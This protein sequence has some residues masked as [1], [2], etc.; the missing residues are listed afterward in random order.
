[1]PT[2]AKCALCENKAQNLLGPLLGP[3]PGFGGS[4]TWCHRLCA[5]WSPEVYQSEDGLL[6]QV[7]AAVRRGR[8][9]KCSSCSRRGATV[10]CRVDS[11]PCCYHLP[12][13]VATHCLFNPQTWAVAC[14]RHRGRFKQEAL[15]LQQQQQQGG[16]GLLS[17]GERPL[18]LGAFSPMAQ[19][20]LPSPA[21]LPWGSSGLRPP[22][23][24]TLS[25]LGP[26]PSAQGS[27][28]GPSSVPFPAPTTAAAAKARAA[29][30][31]AI[32][33]LGRGGRGRGRGEGGGVGSEGGPG[34]RGLCRSGAH[35][36][37][38][39]GSRPGSPGCGPPSKRWKVDPEAVA[40]LHG[41]AQQ[42]LRQAGQE[43]RE[44]AVRAA[45]GPAGPGAGGA[46]E[47][48][49]EAEWAYAERRRLWKDRARLGPVILAGRGAS[50]HSHSHSHNSWVPSQ[51]HR[52]LPL[53]PSRTR[54]VVPC[55]LAVLADV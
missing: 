43:Q 40:A 51:A 22:L 23:P 9:M 10:G 53:G 14:P 30:A 15:A 24:R 31:A 41:A 4:D 32:E 39:R 46:E 3:L 35:Q 29:A 54:G 49:D 25:R 5:L 26:R 6:M 44:A 34:G 28:A 1:M 55:S 48:E 47:G 42:A 17:P 20:K 36:A 33:Q 18:Q 27:R 52:P 11:C 12:C 16:Q 8:A 21:S 38:L 37:G 7:S 19:R 50:P 13:A 45:A 2:L